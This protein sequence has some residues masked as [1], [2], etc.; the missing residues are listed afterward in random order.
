MGEKPVT[1]AIAKSVMSKQI[2]ELEPKLTRNG[3][4]VRGLAEQF[5]TKTAE[6]KTGLR[7]KTLYS[8]SFTRTRSHWRKPAVGTA[9]RRE[10]RHQ[11]GRSKSGK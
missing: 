4:D 11:G 9:S 10:A 2:D 5:H 6:P 7:V 3:Y 8:I 1:A